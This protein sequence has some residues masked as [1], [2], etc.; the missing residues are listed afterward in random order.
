VTVEY[1]RNMKTFRRED[2]IR[3]ILAER[4]DHPGLHEGSR[5]RR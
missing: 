1:I 2:R 5:L 4:G 3:E